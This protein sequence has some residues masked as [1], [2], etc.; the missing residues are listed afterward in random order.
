MS[1][2]KNAAI[3]DDK[4]SRGTNKSMVDD[5]STGA[6]PDAPWMDKWLLAHESEKRHEIIFLY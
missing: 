2:L 4:S 3:A 1:D 5:N 6:Y